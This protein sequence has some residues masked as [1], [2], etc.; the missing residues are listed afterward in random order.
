MS[1]E[2]F[3][4]ALRVAARDGAGIA[5]RLVYSPVTPR[6]NR[7]AIEAKPAG[8]G[9]V[10][11]LACGPDRKVH[12]GIDAAGLAAIAAATGA[13]NGDIG[14]GATAVVAP[15]TLGVL[16]PLATRYAAPASGVGIDVRAGSALVGW[17][18]ER[19]DHPGTSAVVDILALSRQRYIAGVA[20]GADLAL[21]W[22]EKLGVGG[23]LPG[24]LDWLDRVSTGPA[25]PT[26][27]AP[28][29][30]IRSDDDWL[31]ARH[32]DS[33]LNGHSWDSR[34]SLHL[35]A[36][37]LA[38][39]CDAADI[40]AAALFDDPLWR[41]RGVHTGFVCHG[42]VVAGSTSQGRRVMVKSRR[43]DTRLKPGSAV[44]GWSGPPMGPKGALSNQ[45]RGDVFATSVHHGG[46]LLTVGGLGRTDY[47]P[48]AGETV[49]IIAAPPSASLIRSRRQA[50]AGL[51]R[52][53]FSW[54]SQGT[55][56]TTARRAVPLAVLIAAAETEGE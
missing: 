48:A 21:W 42:E 9:R 53:R 5:A 13:V 24:M 45:F 56:P 34:E 55:A 10:A 19:S 25:L 1:A 29:C 46:L 49:T 26:L 28:A 36:A 54:L 14:A 7:V 38:S 17:W 27:T 51:Y 35:A 12:S 3:D 41:A 47:L 23:S 52:Q 43:M 6:P 22:Q 15:A 11:V 31:L 44:L 37:R 2:L 33:I 4:L 30:P 50:V 40:Y 8:R 32:R 18:A 16:A 20:P 39:R